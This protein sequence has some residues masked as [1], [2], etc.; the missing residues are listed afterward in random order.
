MVEGKNI[1]VGGSSSNRGS[2]VILI[3]SKTK[4]GGASGPLAFTSSTGPVHSMMNHTTHIIKF[5]S[6][7]SNIQSREHLLFIVSK[8]FY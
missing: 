1:G 7:L 5:L 6:E 8:V 3:L 2:F 4:K